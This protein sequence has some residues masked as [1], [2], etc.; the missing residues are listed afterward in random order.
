MSREVTHPSAAAAASWE[1]APLVRAAM[2]RVPAVLGL[3]RGAP[4]DGPERGWCR[5]EKGSANFAGP[6]A[7]WMRRSALLLAL[8]LLGSGAVMAQVPEQTV[9]AVS[10]ELEV[11]PT[12]AFFRS[13]VLPGWGQAY[14][15]APV[16]GAVYFGLTGGS[17]W[18]SYLTRKQLQDARR[19][20]EWSRIGQEA[21]TEFAISR[22]RQ[23]EDWV[24]LTLFLMFFSGAD[25]YVAAYLSD[26]DERIGVF[27]TPNGALRM[28]FSL[29]SPRWR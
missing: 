23:F 24:A 14:V 21:E 17:L 6:R 10:Q 18:M 28:E 1:M 19:E 2:S 15:G 4:G 16:R 13:L 27:P 25:A 9:P 26:F 7:H 22:E 12:G 8:F 5:R 20:Q 3:R 29:P 11:S